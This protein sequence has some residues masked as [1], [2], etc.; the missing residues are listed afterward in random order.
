MGGRGRGEEEEEGGIQSG[1]IIII[2]QIVDLEVLV[3][4]LVFLS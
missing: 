1:Y 2:V 4:Q 3:N